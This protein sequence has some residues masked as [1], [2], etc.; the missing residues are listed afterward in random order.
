MNHDAWVAGGELRQDTYNIFKA[1]KRNAIRN[2]T[3]MFFAS[4][5]AKNYNQGSLQVLIDDT[6]RNYNLQ[7]PTNHLR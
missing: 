1:E 5:Q 7:N 4:L 2:I 6:I 3:K